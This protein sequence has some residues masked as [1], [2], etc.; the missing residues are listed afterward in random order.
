MKRFF[1]LKGKQARSKIPLVG[2]VAFAIVFASA[3]Y[4]PRVF[5]Y[6][7]QMYVDISSTGVVSNFTNTTFVAQSY[8]MCEGT[9]PTCTTFNS[10]YNPTVV[11]LGTLSGYGD[12]LENGYR[13]GAAS[14]ADGTYW[15]AF[16]SGTGFSGDVVYFVATRSGGVWTT[17]FGNDTTRI[18]SIDPEDGTTTGNSVTFDVHA[19]INPDDVGS[20]IKIL[21][22]L[23]NIDQNV[24]FASDFSP[25][26]ILLYFGVASTTGDWYFSTT[27][28]LA[29]GNYRFNVL[30]D[31]CATAGTTCLIEMPFYGIHIDESTQFVVNQ[32]TFIG[33]I[34][35]NSARQIN[36]IFA[37]TT[38]TSTAIL[39]QNCNPISGF[40][41]IL[42]LAFLFVPDAGY[43]NDT[44]LSFKDKVSTHFPLGY[45]TD[46]ISIIST[47]T[48]GTLTVV[49]ATLPMFGHPHISLNLAHALDPVLE[50]T[51][52]IF[53]KE[54]AP[55]T[56][57]FYVITSGYW[58]TILYILTAFYILG[59]IF[60]AH[61]IPSSDGLFQNQR[62]KNAKGFAVSDDE[63]RLK[64]KLWQM[65]QKK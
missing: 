47:T 39:S 62:Q 14:T 13:N 40:D 58:N 53:T 60:G 56:D 43:L 28:I 48:E 10:S 64:E 29:D 52:S 5:A 21:F 63:Y 41:P 8:K 11:S 36:H 49:D 34:S 42:C 65:S 6:T 12:T 27:T 15:V 45:V 30:M 24:L 20:V 32:S 57:T 46:F 25:S 7:Q 26:D 37:S 4:A 19:Y 1:H 38:A 17:P 2:I 44:L 23:H 59:R 22:E 54:S 18:I 35:Q 55:S 33:N 51:T 9:Y 3:A 16:Y 61:L 50:A 31:S